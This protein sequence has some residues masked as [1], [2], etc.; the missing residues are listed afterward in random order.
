MTYRSIDAAR[1]LAG[2][3]AGHGDISMMSC[4]LATLNVEHHASRRAIV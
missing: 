4:R 3:M 2:R 1:A